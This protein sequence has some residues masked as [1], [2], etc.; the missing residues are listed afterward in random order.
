VVDTEDAID[1]LPI[2][3]SAGIVH[4]ASTIVQRFGLCMRSIQM[5]SS[6]LKRFD[7][8]TLIYD[9]VKDAVFDRSYPKAVK[10]FILDHP[11]CPEKI[12]PVPELEYVIPVLLYAGVSHRRIMDL[13]FYLHTIRVQNKECE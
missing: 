11:F 8:P 5:S 3:V 4:D 7:A 9:D 2:I 10:S 6:I 13:P 12:T 1:N